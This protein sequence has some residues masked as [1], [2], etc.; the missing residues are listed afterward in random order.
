MPNYAIKK[1]SI[2]GIIYRYSYDKKVKIKDIFTKLNPEDF[3]QIC[4]YRNTVKEAQINRELSKRE[5]GMINNFKRIN[6]SHIQK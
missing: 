3:L 6:T 5:Q 1:G 2:Y 4:K